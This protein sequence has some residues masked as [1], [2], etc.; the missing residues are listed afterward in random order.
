MNPTIS[1][2]IIMHAL[3]RLW[4]ILPILFGV[5]Q[6]H[7]NNPSGN[8]RIE[9]IAGYNF[10]VRSNIESQPGTS[11]E[12]AYLAAKFC[13]DGT[14]P[15]TNVVAYIG[16]FDDGNSPTPG[17]YP[18]SNP[19]DH[20]DLTGPIGGSFAL[21]H[22][23]GLF[24]TADATRYIGTIEPG[25][26][27][28]VYWLV[29][30]PLVDENGKAT[31]G[32][33]VKPD[34]DLALRFDIWGEA[35]DQGTLFTAD[36]DRTVFMRNMLQ[37][38]ANKIQPNNANKVPQEY[39]DLLEIY[40][41]TWTNSVNDGSPGT[42]F[43]TEGYWY[44]LGNINQGFDN[45]G[46]LVPDYNVWMQP[47]GDPSKFDPSCFRL[48]STKTLL[49]IKRSGGQPDYVIIAED[50]LYFSKLPPDNTGGIG[51]VI[52]E[53]MPLRSGCTSQLTPY[54]AVA[55][56]K[57]NEKFNGDYG[58]TLGEGLFSTPS[59]VTLNKDV[60][61]PVS[62]A[63]SNLTYTITYTNTG[64]VE[65]G[66]PD[67]GMPLVISD[68]I[69]A[70]ATYVAGSAATGNVLPSGVTEY[71][72]FYSTNNATSWTQTEPSPASDVTD[73]Q[74]WLSD[75]LEVDANGAVTFEVEVDDPAPPLIYNVA[76]LSFGNTVPFAEDDATTL[77]LGD[78]LIS[79]TV[80]ED[81]GEGGGLSGNGIQDGDEPGISN[82]TVSL[83]FDANGD[84][85]LDDG[86]VLF[87]TVETDED[88]NYA[89]TDLPDGD[90]IIVVNTEDPDLP[91]GYTP[92][93]PSSIAVTLDDDDSTGNDFG[94]A[95]GLTLEKTGPALV[96]KGGQA[97]YS[98]VVSNSLAATSETVEYT[99]WATNYV[100]AFE[101]LQGNRP[102]WVNPQNA[103]GAPDGVFA[104]H[105]YVNADQR[106]GLG[107]FTIP[108]SSATITTVQVVVAYEA[109]SD[110]ASWRANDGFFIR[111]YTNATPTDPI[112]ESVEYLPLSIHGGDGTGSGT[113][114]NDITLS[115]SWD[116][117]FFDPANSNLF[118]SVETDRQGGGRAITLG[119]DAAGF[120]VTTDAQL[121]LLDSVPLY[122]YYD[123]SILQF[124]SAVP[125]VTSSDNDGPAPNTGRLFWDNVGPLAPT[126][127]TNITVTF[128]VIG[129]AGSAGAITTNAAV[130]TNATYNTGALANEAFDEAETEVP[131]T[132]SIGD[133]IFWDGN[134]SGSQDAGEEGIP[135]VLVELY[136]NATLVASQYTDANGVYLFTNLPPGAYTVVVVQDDGDP[137]YPL[138]GAELTADPDADGV[139]CWSPLAIGCNNQT[140]VT[141]NSGED[142][143]GAD[144][145]YDPPGGTIGGTLWIDFNANDQPDPGEDGLAF[146]PVELYSN[147][148]LV[149]TTLTDA[150]GNYLFY[151]L[152]D[153]NYS[154]HVITND[155]D[156]PFPPGLTQTYD[157]DGFIDNIATNI[158]VSGGS[159]V[160]VDG[161]PC[162]NCDLRNDFGYRYAGN[163]S[164]SGTVGLDNPEDIDGVLNGTNTS[165]VAT[166]EVA[167]AGVTVFAYLWHDLDG[168]GVVDPGETILVGTTVT[169]ANGDYQFT[170][171]PDGFDDNPYYI[172]SL[173]APLTYLGLTTET[174]SVP[175]P[176]FLVVDNLNLQGHTVSAYQAVE[177]EPTI[178]NVDFAFVSLRDYDFGDLPDSY[179]TLLPNGARHAVN[180]N[181]P[182]LYL[183]AGV[184]V[185]PNGQPSV[186]ADADDFDDGVDVVGIWQNGPN[187]ASVQVTVG[188]GSGWLVGFVDFNNSGAFD[189]ANELI[190]SEAVSSTGGPDSDGVYTFTFNVPADSLSTDSTTLLYSRFRL[191]PSQPL[192]PVLAYQGEADNGEVEDYRWA[193]NAISG[194]VYWDADTN[195]VFSGGDEPQPGVIIRLYD[196]DTNLVAETVTQLDGSYTFYGLPNGDYRIEMDTPD[197]ANAILDADGSANGNDLIEVTL[198]NSSMVDQDFLLDDQPIVG[199]ISGTVWEDD[200]FGVEG[201][202]EFDANDVPVQGVLVSLYRDIN[203]DGSI[204]PNEFIASV[205]T[206]INGEYSFEN[207]PD[208][209][210]IIFM[211]TPTGA[212]SID[213]AD[214]DSNGTDL[215][216]VTIENGEDEDNQDFLIDGSTN[217]AELSGLIWFDASRNGIR[218]ASET[219]RFS[220]V[221]VDLL[222]ASSNVVDSTTTAA[223]GTYSFTNITPGTY[224][225]RF[226]LTGLTNDYDVVSPYQGNDPTRDSDVTT[227]EGVYAYTEPLLLLASQE[228]EHIDLGLQSPAPTRATLAEV[229]GE[230]NGQAEV[231]W[232]TLSEYGTAAFMVYRIDPKTGTETPLQDEWIPSAL[233]SGGS[234]TYRM[235]DPTMAEGARALYR[236]EELEGQG[237]VRDL[238]LH[239]VQFSLPRVQQTSLRSLSAEPTVAL[240]SSAVTGPETSDCLKVH[241]RKDGIYAVTLDSIATQM[242]QSLSFV[243]ELAEQGEL[244]IR[245]EGRSIPYLYDDENGRL[246]FFGQATTDWYAQDAVYWIRQETGL[247]MDR[248]SP[249]G[250][251]G[252]VTVPVL[253]RIEENIYPKTYWDVLDEDWYYW[254]FIISNTGGTGGQQYP[255]TLEGY[256]GGDVSL[257]VKLIGYLG[258]VHQAWFDFNGT[259]VGGHTFAD[260]DTTMVELTIP[261]SLVNGASNT[262]RVRGQLPTGQQV[263][264]FVMDWIEVEYE[265]TLS[266]STQSIL[267]TLDDAEA[268]SAE[269]FEN[270]LLL[271][272]TDP[273]APVHVAGPDGRLTTKQATA[274]AGDRLALMEW[275]EIPV[276]EPVAGVCDAW[277][278]ASDN[279]IDYLVITSRDLESAAWE[280]AE[281]RESQG[282]R[283]GVALFDEVCDL[284]ADGLRTPLAI[285]SFLRH[286]H[287][288]W[289]TAPWLVVL[290]GSGHND[291]IHGIQQEIN[292]LPPLLSESHDGVFA[293]DGLLADIAG[294]G[295]P[296]LAIG[297]LPARAAQE[298]QVMID[299]IR[300]YEM[301][302][303]E[304]WHQ[305]IVLNA[306]RNDSSGNDFV[307]SSE[308][309]AQAADG[310]RVSRIY[311][312][313][314]A[315]ADA[316]SSLFGHFETGA[317]FVHYTGHGNI[318]NWGDGRVL[319]R[320]ADIPNLTH[321]RLPVVIA[322]TCLAGRF[323]DYWTRESLSEQL[324]RRMGGGAVAVWSASGMSYN[325]P[326]TQLG[327]AFYRLVYQEGVGTL[328][329][330]IKRAQNEMEEEPLFGTTFTMYNLLGDPATKLGGVQG[331]GRAGQQFAQWRWETFRPDELAN[332][333]ISGPGAH[334]L[335]TGRNN[336][337][338]YA[339]GGAGLVPGETPSGQGAGGG[340]RTNQELTN[341]EDAVEISWT[342]RRQSQDIIYRISVS[343]DLLTWTPNPPEL[344]IFSRT[345]SSDGIMDEV[346]ARLPFDGERLY[347]KLDVIHQ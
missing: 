137:D 53:F 150:D 263:G 40:A 67:V 77:I 195:T 112:F 329:T 118:I 305:H 345:P 1:Y 72:I 68:S 25:E 203:N 243:R 128:D 119:I 246:L 121:G 181:A 132:G 153:G 149:A 273:L 37:A 74:W 147:G 39:L 231:V 319:L 247:L 10:V 193:F 324:L 146:I 244:G 255:V 73:I 106:L 282:L 341:E 31:H 295:R 185:E 250:A 336:F 267:F 17:I 297:R 104:T 16:N 248:L 223:D 61:E 236:L 342:E 167:F 265:R 113:L 4:V 277:F 71:I 316:R 337:L 42:S 343:T 129:P 202:G 209:D 291:Y 62:G 75:P 33:S 331:N 126:E 335:S 43:L 93:S 210:Y 220:G 251:A 194:T 44:D 311:L 22:E 127:A 131:P 172:V 50:Q 261:A 105:S 307:A 140:T 152:P 227:T 52:Y 328:G 274:Q 98:I 91:Q 289:R 28:A 171:L 309:L 51:L 20:P 179:S 235:V 178:T 211:T 155:V 200:G 46:D 191:F 198:N 262:L 304:D 110:G 234:P 269:T 286:A 301:S 120:I 242:D 107:G 280:L 299:K 259:P 125:T 111:V 241:V 258:A 133:T 186:W 141:L 197:G 143:L 176:S 310:T 63:G 257:Q 32:P 339:L 70:G 145:G 6:A 308:T 41:P 187:G 303:G 158:L 213:D 76:G 7:A 156:F 183:G 109:F 344:Q 321:D 159:V 161:D 190:V 288:Q 217:V 320:H 59:S 13:N 216:Q 221:T 5:H 101:N 347:I 253:K 29:S 19:A 177:I 233:I 270:P 11:P 206:D 175:N 122:D 84:G 205:L 79:G 180:T 252:R 169:D 279:Q 117:T 123:P 254:N 164:L 201:N 174:N 49:V 65:V 103:L 326:A 139:P 36:T 224:T 81:T 114:T 207:L 2:T 189:N 313:E 100:A 35:Y 272:V 228:E 34:D 330:A 268:V 14:E 66:Q 92:T 278:M 276:L 124:V 214:G 327:E 162:T 165:G 82:I 130:I 142:F 173:S 108:S 196:A 95:P 298:L 215:I 89:F 97:V 281:Y 48:V 239:E 192:F 229:W 238:G 58:A 23:G 315:I 138:I 90:Y 83:Y 240:M 296:D 168:D 135:G 346:E 148:T 102:I 333:G 45:D 314:M 160:S 55:S 249:E 294:N 60:D 237:A 116:W 312:D 166:G 47:V 334:G 8:L 218:E 136:S 170:N 284:F 30:Y 338:M 9:L 154:V 87:A 256:A 15:L 222:D 96:E 340:P 157:R 283:V 318:R 302:H 184:S 94:F 115:T 204:D 24:G 182:T 80:F 86:D 85:V 3:M 230:W 300:A 208:G 293:A 226:D 322:L 232:E 325:Q 199:N 12:S 292:H 245:S 78:N 99:A 264:Y 21:T 212:D 144:F 285:Q 56:G 151:G 323:E 188:A 38:Q 26:C 219:N 271:I 290:A 88:G 54:Q 266:P 317:G 275:S 332:P 69:P 18:L 163:N 134:R 225:V 260:K 287:E 64:I 306:D 27:V 57:D